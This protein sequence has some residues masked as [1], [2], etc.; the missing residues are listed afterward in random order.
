MEN[1]PYE[2]L[3]RIACKLEIDSIL[4]FSL[5]VSQP[6][7]ILFLKDQVFFRR[8]CRRDFD[9]PLALVP[10]IQLLPCRDLYMMM[11]NF[12]HQ[13]HDECRMALRLNPRYPELEGDFLSTTAKI[14][15]YDH[16]RCDFIVSSLPC[17]DDDDDLHGEEDIYSNMDSET[18]P[19]V[20][21]R[22]MQCIRTAELEK[23]RVM[24]ICEG[25]GADIADE[26]SPPG[27][28]GLV[29]LKEGLCVW[30]E[31]PEKPEACRFELICPMLKI[32]EIVSRCRSL[33]F[34]ELLCVTDSVN[35]I[36]RQKLI[37]KY[38]LSHPQ[39]LKFNLEGIWKSLRRN[40]DE[41]DLCLETIEITND[42]QLL[43]TL[44]RR[45][46]DWH[47]LTWCMAKRCDDRIIDCSTTYCDPD[48]LIAVK[49]RTYCQYHLYKSDIKLDALNDCRQRRLKIE[50][51]DYLQRKHEYEGR[52]RMPHEF[53]IIPGLDSQGKPTMLYISL[54]RTYL[55]IRNIAES[56]T[57]VGNDI[58]LRL[59][60]GTY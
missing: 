12:R 26:C 51:R 5:V 60:R 33:V 52:C 50:H 56:G 38:E 2:V 37:M 34:S 16:D 31:E 30:A 58:Q 42:G 53:S 6:G 27:G 1:L 4:R 24:R 32:E 19:L 23:Y 22:H 28:N 20:D 57:A 11:T 35:I 29:V 9:C 13:L 36:L 14:Y 43:L 41:A 7:N 25:D 40:L 39:L 17:I 10:E 45:D 18:D 55:A 49:R 47:S 21:L 46:P 15:V 8:L 54:R 44:K 48:D 3:V 59:D